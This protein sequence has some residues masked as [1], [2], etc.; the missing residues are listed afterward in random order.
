MYLLKSITTSADDDEVAAIL[1]MTSIDPPRRQA[2][3]D[4]QRIARSAVVHTE[5][6][7]TGYACL[8][9]SSSVRNLKSAP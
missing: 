2:I 3:I 5:A 6:A 7:L 4:L 1:E 9:G 8:E